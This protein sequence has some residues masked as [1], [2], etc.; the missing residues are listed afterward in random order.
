MQL[1]WCQLFACCAVRGC[2]HSS[3]SFLV[4]SDSSGKAVS[5]AHRMMLAALCVPLSLHG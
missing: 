1:V 4:A 3:G 5:L 2:M